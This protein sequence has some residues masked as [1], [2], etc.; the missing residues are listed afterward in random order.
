[1]LARSFLSS[2]GGE[3]SD[4]DSSM[5]GE[6]DM[7]RDDVV[8]VWVMCWAPMTALCERDEQTAAVLLLM[9]D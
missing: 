5:S 1:M 3:E 2:G 6:V 7:R 9:E 4:V 8:D